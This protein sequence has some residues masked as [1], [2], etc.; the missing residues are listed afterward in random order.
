[1]IPRMKSMRS[2]LR[3]ALLL[4]LSLPTG[5]F[6]QE[7]AGNDAAPRG[8]LLGVVLDAETR[9][10]LAGANVAVVS[11]GRGASS[12]TEGRFRITALP[13]GSCALRVSYLGYRTH[14]ATD[15][16]IRSAAA[17]SVT[18][19]LQPDAIRGNEV[20][21]RA[22]YFQETGDAGVSAVSLSPEEIRREAGTGGDISRIIVA[23]PSVAKGNDTRNDLV[24]RGGSPIEN[25]FFVD[26]IEIPNI[27]HYPQYGASG[28]AIGILN[29]NAISDVD[30]SAGGFAARYGDRLSSVMSISLREGSREAAAARADLH[31]MGAGVQAEG[32]LPGADASWFLSAR[33]SWLDFLL[34]TFSSEV[35]SAMPVYGDVHAKFVWH[36]TGGHTLSLLDIYAGDASSNEREDARENGDASF[37]HLNSTQNT[38]GL[39][40]TWV[41]GEHGYSNT[42]IAHNAQRFDQGYASVASGALLQRNASSEDALRLRSTHVWRVSA[43]H[44]LEAGLEAAFSRSALDAEYGA[45]AAIP[46]VAM[47]S[48][49]RDTRFA[50]W[51]GSAWKPHPAFTLNS[52]LRADHAAGQGIGSFSPRV[53]LR[54]DASP[55]SSVTLAA[56]VYRQI[57]PAVLRR[58]HEANRDLPSP[59]ALH[60]VAGYSLLLQEHMRALLEVYAKEYRSMPLDP[61]EPRGFVLDD[62]ARTLD[63]F[64]AHGPL[65]ASGRARA[66][67]AEFSVQKKLV[68]DLYG[69]VSLSAGRAEYRAIDGVW[70]ARAC[71]NPFSAA[72][73]GGY[74]FSR[75]WEA[76][77]RWILAGGAP[78]TP[79]D[80][81]ASIAAGEGVLDAAQTSAER[82]PAYHSLN[83]RV[84]K[85]FFF[86]RS[87]LTCW[88]AVWNLYGRENIPFYQWDASARQAV[89]PTL[90]SNSALPVFGVEY[91]F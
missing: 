53:S 91:D 6:A 22:G 39:A 59:E 38:A 1:M 46:A 72:L 64:G 79:F 16:V 67:G 76:S 78:F 4:L 43:A 54:W 63:Y 10:P 84:D 14:T 48:T 42:T 9:T 23:L 29:I 87:T 81:A 34:T 75:D 17:T 13:V 31:F 28:G 56:G 90:W 5:V 45:T 66:I 2:A 74:K 88:L 70:R 86:D 89:A 61:A 77:V 62:L 32:P 19:A 18:I 80:V 49:Y 20:I 40:W 24:V 83:L 69:T 57:L 11:A 65:L 41:W 50:V 58:Q 7:T 3:A 30:F 82:L 68:S 25:T 15:V 36:L 26:G 12:D 27:N 60:L 8:I 35:P 52:G 55:V 73:M 37:G 33:R 71:D 21:V 51:L 47:R 44:S 85:R